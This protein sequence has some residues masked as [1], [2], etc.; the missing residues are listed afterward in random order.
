[1]VL[2]SCPLQGGAP[3]LLLVLALRR[4]QARLVPPDGLPQVGGHEGADDPQ[5]SRKNESGGFV[6]PWMKKL[7]NNTGNKADDDQPDDVHLSLPGLDQS[8]THCG[9][10][11]FPRPTA[12]AVD[13]GFCH[14]S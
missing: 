7:S 1:M 10:V 4:L 11:Q 5:Y 2:L 6:A 12:A 8:K 3:A 13:I 9:R 14:G